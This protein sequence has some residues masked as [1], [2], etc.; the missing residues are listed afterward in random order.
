MSL[1]NEDRQVLTQLHLDK[2]HACLTEGDCW[3]W[4]L[5]LLQQIVFI[6]LSTMIANAQNHEFCCSGIT[7][8]SYMICEN[9][10]SLR[11]LVGDG[12]REN[13]IIHIEFPGVCTINERNYDSKIV[14]STMK[15]NTDEFFATLIYIRDKALEWNK[16]LI[17]RGI[18]EYEKIYKEVDFPKMDA[19]ITIDDNVHHLWNNKRNINQA[20]FIKKS[21]DESS[22][23]VMHILGSIMV[24]PTTSYTMPMSGDIEMHCEELDKLIF[25]LSDAVKLC[26]SGLDIEDLLED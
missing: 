4:S 26:E 7:V 2:A 23:I 6:I 3:L 12:K 20:K 14:F 22:I 16:I 15:D 21:N 10:D 11:V 13:K 18:D 8:G 1:T 5:Y 17:S 24:D 9:G 25:L 19:C